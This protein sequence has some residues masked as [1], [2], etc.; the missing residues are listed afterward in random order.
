MIVCVAVFN[1]LHATL[2]RAIAVALALF[3]T[4][5]MTWRWGEMRR[6]PAVCIV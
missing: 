4:A 2:F 1:D 5:T 6:G 3:A